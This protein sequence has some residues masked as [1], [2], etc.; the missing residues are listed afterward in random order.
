M[1]DDPYAHIEVR[2]S[3]NVGLLLKQARSCTNLSQQLKT[4]LQQLSADCATIQ[5]SFLKEL[6]EQLTKFGVAGIS[7]L[8]RIIDSS[9]IVLPPPNI[10]PRNIVVQQRIDSLTTKFANMEYSRMTR[11]L[12]PLGS[13]S[14]PQPSGLQE[15]RCMNKQI[16]MVLNFTLVVVC[17]F[18]FGYFLSDIFGQSHATPGQ[19]IV[20]GFSLALLVFFA[21]L[22]F[23][24]K[25]VD[26]C[27]NSK[28]AP[29]THKVATTW[30]LLQYWTTCCN[31]ILPV[32]WD[33]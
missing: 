6:H 16:L 20:C 18:V 24:V 19:R 10:P 25:N 1:S 15:L 7:P 23:L 13:S 28:Q 14:K 12:G 2:M 22:Y 26:A 21:D 5:F 32:S 27:D 4:R 8:W 17:S 3:E 31:F 9:G 11:S 33:L 29:S 30:S